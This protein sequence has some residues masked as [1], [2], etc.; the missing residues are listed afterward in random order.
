M[1]Q[2]HWLIVGIVVVALIALPVWY[3]T[4]GVGAQTLAVSATSA[5]NNGSDGDGTTRSLRSSRNRSI[6][7]GARR[8]GK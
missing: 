2:L 6:V 7:G 1:K 4:N 3:A 5:S 8:Y